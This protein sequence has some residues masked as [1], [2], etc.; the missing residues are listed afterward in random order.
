MNEQAIQDAYNLFVQKGYKGDVN[1]FSNL[2]KT[3]PNALNDSY[4][5]FVEGGY[6]KSYDDYKTLV[7]VNQAQSADLLKKKGQGTMAQMV[8]QNTTESFIQ[9]SSLAS[10]EKPQQKKKPGILAQQ[11]PKPTTESFLETVSVEPST[12]K[13]GTKDPLAFL[14]PSLKTITPELINKNEEFV[15]PKMNYQF[16]DIGF[17]F[18][19]SGMT[20]DWMKATAPNG[21][22]I[23]VSL[24]PLFSSTAGSE[25][26]KL[27]QFIKENS[28][29]VKGLSAI[30]RS[31]AQENKKFDTQKD[32]DNSIGK[33]N[34]EAISLN[35][36]MNNFLKQKKELDGQFAELSN[37]PAAVKNTPEYK[38]Q[39]QA[40][41]QQQKALELQR[42]QIADKQIGI[43]NK[44]KLLDKAIGRY[45][46]MK[47]E[48]GTR[49][50]ATWNWLLEG[51]SSIASGMANTIIDLGGAFLPQEMLMAPQQWK[52]ESV[53]VAKEL[54]IKEPSAGQ[55]EDKWFN[56]LSKSDKD[57]IESKMRDL[58]KKQ[59]KSDI[60][61]YVREGNRVALGDSTTTTEYMNLQEKG[62]WGGAYAGLV[63]SLPA[64]IGARGSGLAAKLLTQAAFYNQISDGLIQEM[65]NNPAFKDVSENEKALV[66]LPIGIAGA[67]LEEYGLKNIPGAKGLLNKIAFNALSKAGATTTARSFKE[68]VQNEVESM[69]AKGALTITAAGLAEA[70][71][72]G[73]QQIAEFGVKDIYNAAKGTKMFDNPQTFTADWVKEVLKSAGQEAVGGFI[74]GMP[75][76]V[77]SAYSKKGFLNMDDTTFRTF[78]AAANDDNIQKAFVTKLKNQVNQGDITMEQA[79]E[80]LNNYRN[81]VGLFKSMPEGL[82]LEGKKEAMNLLKEKRDL[83]NQIIGK[84]AALVKPQADRISA[85]NESLTKLSENA[86]QEQT[87]GQVPVQSETGT[88]VQ[89]AEGEPQ[90]EPQGVTQE[91][92]AE[93]V[94]PQVKLTDDQIVEYNPTEE[95]ADK[96]N[97]V[98]GKTLKSKKL[99]PQA[100][101]L[102]TDLGDSVVF[103]YNNFD[104]NETNTRLIF[105][106][107]KDGSISGVGVKL[108][109]N[110]GNIRGT[111]LFKNYVNSKRTAAQTDVM[112]QPTQEIETLRAQEQTELLEAIPNAENYVV[113]GKVDRTKISD[114]NDLRTFDEIY[115]KYD[116]LI[117]PL[118]QTTEVS[119][120]TPSVQLSE[121]EQIAQME[122][123]FSGQ[124]VPE[125]PTTNQ[126]TS[127]TNKSA[128]Q[129]VKS[130]LKDAQKI[131]IVDSA[132]RV[133]NTLKS[134][135]P[136]F[137]IVVHDSDDSY[138]AA[139][140]SVNGNVESAGNFSYVKNP[141]GS[142]VGRID[143][144]LNKANQR[145]VSHEVAHGIMLKAFGENPEVF[146]MFKNRIA[147]VL[148]KSSNKQLQEFADQYAEVD[149]YEEYLAELTALLEQQEEN[150]APNTLQK[151][152]A[153]INDLVSKVTNGAFKPFQDIKDTKQAVEFFKNISTSIRKGEAI[154]ESDITAI[155]QGLS[156]PIGS[157]TTIT[158][159]AQVPVLNKFPKTPFPLS[160]VT[161][162]DK[163]D[164]EALI[165][166][167]VEK[168]QKV[169]FWMADQLGR[170]YYYDEVIEGEH[171][172]D[173]GPSFALDPEN[174][175]N[176]LLWASGLAEKT[177]A[178]QIS[179]ADYIFFISGSP[180]KAKLF[181]K[182]V[183]NLLEERI[184]KKSDFNTFKKA[185]NEFK[186]ET[187]E[188]KTMKE[189]LNS[190]ESFKELAD[191]PKRKPFLLALGEVASLKTTPMGSLKEL[192]DSFNA[193][194]DYNELRDGFYKENGFTQ[195][196]IMLVGKPTGL[197]GKAPHSTYEF[198]ISGEVVGVPDKKINSWNIMPESLKEKYQNVIG[199]KEAKTKPLQTKVIAAETGVVRG[200]E[201]QRKS[202]AQLIG[203]NA[204]LSAIAKFNLNLAEQMSKKKKS[205]QDIRIITGWE[206]GLDGKWRYEIPDG[207]FKDIDIYD[208]KK[209]SNAEGVTVRT[210]KLSD[211]FS[212][213]ELYQAYPEAKDIKAEFEKLPFNEYGSYDRRNNTVT[214]NEELYLEKKA[215]AELTM[216]HEIQH[217]IQEKEFFE[218]GA[219]LDM[220]PFMMSYILREFKD[221]VQAAGE[222]YE[223]YKLLFANDKEAVEGARK[224]YELA[225]ERYKKAEEL[226][227]EKYEKKDKQ[228]LKDLS[229]K[230]GV[231]MSPDDI[232][233]KPLASAFNLYYRVAGEVEARNIEYRNKLTPEER[234][235]TLLSETEN[236]DRED[237][238][239]FKY[240]D[241]LF[242]E[243]NNIKEEFP[244]SK[245]Q[246]NNDSKVAK[247]I[248]DARAQG[249]SENAIKTFLQGKGL[250]DSQ[251]DEAMGNEPS[252]AKRVTLSEE[253]FP[254]YD[255]LMSRI[256]SYVRTGLPLKEI[257]RR[258]KESSTY[259]NATDIQ[260]EKLVRDIR[261]KLGIKEKSAPMAK[262]II[263]AI[264][265]V[266]KITMSEKDLLK[267]QIKDLARGAK[268]AKKIWMEVSDS[269]SKEI[270]ELA[271]SGK[272]TSK[273]VAAVIRKFSAVNMFSKKSIDNFVD[274]MAK[275][276]NNAEYASKLNEAYSLKG[277]ISKLANNK[278]KDPNLR[279][280]AKK[281]IDINPSMVEDIDAYNEMAS[282]IKEAIKGSTIRA[283][284]VTFASTVNI[285]NAS[286]YIDKTL[287]T[288]N[289]TIR[290]QKAEEIQELMGVDASDLSY[291]DMM[292]LLDSKEPITKYNEGIIRSTINKMFD[293]YSTIIKE[294]IR[295]GKNQFTEENVEFTDAQKDLVKRFMEMDLNLLKPKEALQA[296][297]ALNNFLNNQSTAKMEAVLSDYTGT[298]NAAI[299]K[300][301]KIVAQPLTKYWSKALGRFLGEQTTNLNVLFERMFKGVTRGGFVED[302][303][304]VT[305][306][307][308]GKAR[309]ERLANNIVNEYVN[310]FYKTKANGE[311]F[312]TDYNDIERGIAARMM[313]NIMGTQ[314]EMQAEFKRRK[315]LIEESIKELSEGNELEQKKAELYQKAYD[316]IV[317]D[318]KNVSDIKSKLDPKNAEAVDWWINEWADKFP[319]L[320]DVSENVYN[321]ILEKDLNYTPD[322]FSNL[323]ME[324][325]TVELSNDESAFHRN[326]GTI[327]KKET[328]VLMA[329]T[330]PSKLP[331]NKNG[332]ASM[333]LDLSF[334]KNNANAMYDALVDINTAAP[335]RQVESFL[336][337]RDF[338]S[339]VPQAEDAKI[340]KDRINL[341]V[342]NIRNKNPYTNDELSATVRRLNKI[343]A[344]GV[345]QALGG[346]LQ[347]I[348]Q[349]VP[350]A[351]NTLVNGGSL[352]I[353]S[354]FNKAKT[355]FL[356]NSGYAIA[357]RGIESQAQIE[358]INKLIELA[359]QSTG[360]KAI[361]FLEKA[362]KKWLEIFLVKPDV[363]VARASWMTYYE[364]SLKKQGIDPKGIDYNTHEVNEKAGN[365]AQRMVDRQQN[366][367]DVDLAGKLFVNKESSNQILV[368]M[369]MAFASFRMNQSA[370]LGSDLA[371]MF[372][373]TATEEDKNIA[374][375]S[376]IGYG[377]ESVMF[378]VISAASII[379][380]G[381]I[382]KKALGM[383]E[384]D[385]EFKKRVNDVVK[386]QMTSITTDLFSPLPIVD[387]GVQFGVSSTLGLVQDALKISK[388]KQVNIYGVSKQSALQNLGMFG[389]TGERALQLIELAN[390]AFTGTYTDDFGNTKK[391]SQ[392][393]QNALKLMIAP[394]LLT[395]VGLLPTEVSSLVRNTVK[396]SKK[397]YKSAEDKA[398]EAER[399]E[400]REETKQQ[401]ISTLEDIRKFTDNPDEI[402]AINREIYELSADDEQKAVIKEERKKERKAK[403]ALLY[404]PETGVE[405]D[406][407]SDVK[408]YNPR[409]YNENFGPDSQ[410]YKDHKWERDIEKK[411]N[412]Q[413]REAEEEEF[414]YTP[415][416]KSDGFGS[417]KGFNNSKSKSKSKSGFGGKGGFN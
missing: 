265:N 8:P 112:A 168:K 266:T 83:E 241:L 184:N 59:V 185:I 175:K 154:K 379:A 305:L 152:A 179:E 246:L 31:Y 321:K 22:T 111:D 182:R 198:G 96:N 340:L 10:Q 373:K 149:S 150:I 396:F 104:D 186:K 347:P 236:I 291:E 194:I 252:A 109:T 306:L 335:I 261:K 30:E 33:I 349:V 325:G 344:V 157:P 320:S 277:D 85:I 67:V 328:G 70:E 260:K 228:A 28:A 408:K 89:V 413:I 376:L 94:T 382:A 29:Q 166:E 93:E 263:G 374:N 36:E 337:S 356:N 32:V 58:S 4:N 61:P 243:V 214:I 135:L 213:P 126:G 220:A 219:N 46:D 377:V 383:D 37:V 365:Y 18:E 296:V 230:S 40:V 72:G 343:A 171:Y 285:E 51:S 34:D 353:M 12:Q 161:E 339:I 202:K 73:A 231:K 159:K 210:A 164:I 98:L 125:N 334:D 329:A 148:S 229:D 225:K 370:R 211:V 131:A 82:D 195:N 297:D 405:Y 212:A 307:K 237:Q 68:F 207:K 165:D 359:S 189:A 257:L 205:A 192:L 147:S 156:V 262:R 326:N 270:K 25:S 254:G 274:Y 315:D 130:K 278:D 108:E 50:G 129:Q 6:S 81:S 247:V 144:N 23:E 209:E 256:D 414:N 101:P 162:A 1:A 250:S 106:K 74:M 366:V 276:F 139:M 234:R 267:K 102:I 141:D 113:D 386:G 300:G 117:T 47:S 416:S 142:F 342:R 316:K 398:E 208:L 174:R 49:L 167:I 137:D 258:I 90:A 389:I 200:L 134:V 378:R 197:A 327:Y 5:L 282:K 364:Q 9:E 172:L 275:A 284:K 227:F 224:K 401:K 115:D 14:E 369:L 69:I 303:S 244:I 251:I 71:T 13:V 290:R 323:S 217:F 394:A 223:G 199:G 62:F 38:A 204:Q 116:K 41:L 387:K 292:S 100:E 272:I 259:T 132:Q 190:V 232:Y 226:N 352:D 64:M 240:S 169:W 411:M 183:L 287:A 105:N 417:T 317:K 124:E 338:K 415:K 221:N 133:L 216:L 60:L 140:G 242:E 155:Q 395:N 280:V 114:P 123:M 143:I 289:E 119:S 269:L 35:K 384:D 118:L 248:K 122:K 188:L 63:K 299:V 39:A 304:G 177:L 75:T 310:K 371:V 20:G 372:D 362:N 279:A 360:A 92:K 7:G 331:T 333:Y 311:A 215:E 55:S 160:F 136:N 66:I 24:D 77:S 178:K 181:N 348:K 11:F 399:A 222:R 187:V 15:V 84:D 110:T 127:V 128:L 52:S 302:M 392:E 79:K 239:M 286:E 44:S 380:L 324:T 48:Q 402:N 368:K 355:N 151:I 281:F 264:R 176:N 381:T 409:L 233:G 17:K 400:E 412:K 410:W 97:E 235:K 153:A 390:L 120:K 21:K 45:A 354:Q 393:G 201:A 27:K 406:N 301:K 54:G 145:T 86:I 346:I 358:S 180:E 255:A 121:Q 95:V 388:E 206:K 308:N 146:K 404:D 203:Q 361:E 283:E 196:D 336:N 173:A 16:G 191:S 367:S 322:K 319:Q 385:D 138:S 341:Y 193:F 91:V 345:G 19:E 273:Q 363:F 218:S 391:I 294:T 88:S 65:D 350:V 403:E 2:I 80:T 253:M 42:K 103:E 318:S 268:D 78:E 87:A 26:E 312:N 295:T 288:Q 330:K 407:E 170:G 56:S 3:N 99:T 107:K 397:K 357:N 76:A 163:I 158:S 313:R 298:K 249:F 332:D 314:A 375:R 53:R 238:I 351:F 57:S 245:S 43:D 309:A 293:I 271:S